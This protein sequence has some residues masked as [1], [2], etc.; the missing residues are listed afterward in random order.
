MSPEPQRQPTCKPGPT[1]PD[2]ALGSLSS[3]C[4]SSEAQHVPPPQLPSRR[5]QAGVLTAT[6]SLHGDL[7]PPLSWD[8]M[9]SRSGHS[10]SR[11][12]S[13]PLL[14][15]WHAAHSPG[16]PLAQP[17]PQCSHLS[18]TALPLPKATWTSLVPSPALPT[19]RT[20][21]GTHS[22]TACGLVRPHKHWDFTSGT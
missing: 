2:R 6:L 1:E 4:P 19:A 8:I 21:R 7:L 5:A 9:S 13:R 17:A 14:G 15:A 11:S 10:S 3:Q 16:T 18:P 20:L 22:V 12:G